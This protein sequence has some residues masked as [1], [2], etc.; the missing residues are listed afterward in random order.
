[1]ECAECDN[2]QLFANNIF[3]TKVCCYGNQ[4]SMRSVYSKI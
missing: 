4:S 1:M 3:V 2:P